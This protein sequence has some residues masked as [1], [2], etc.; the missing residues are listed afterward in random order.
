MSCQMKTEKAQWMGMP[1]SKSPMWTGGA[2][3]SAYMANMVTLS[4]HFTPN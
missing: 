1:P 4:L 3:F 2:M